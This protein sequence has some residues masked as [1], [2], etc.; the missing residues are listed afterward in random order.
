MVF[1]TDPW[2]LVWLSHFKSG[3]FLCGWLADW[4]AIFIFSRTRFIV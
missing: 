1:I 4:L 3:P 2:I